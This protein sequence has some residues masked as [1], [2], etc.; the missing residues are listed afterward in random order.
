MKYGVYYAYWETQW[1]ADYVKYCKKV[2][3]LGF[4]I[5]EIAG[6]GLGDMTDGERRELRDVSKDLGIT[7]TTGIGLPADVNVSSLDESVRRKG[8]DYMKHLIR[9][10]DAIDSR[11]IGGTV[12]AYWPADYSKPFDKEAERAQS[13]K[14]VLELSDYAADYGVT[15]LIET[16]NRFE[17]YLINDSHE[18]LAYM[19]DVNRENVKMLLDVFHMNIEEDSIAEGIRRLK[20]YIGEIHAGEKNRKVPGK[21]TMPWDEFA[22]ALHEVGFDGNV[23]ME[24]F[25]RPGGIVGSDVKLWRDLSGGADEAKLDQDIAES[26]VFLKGKLEK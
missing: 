6:G 3:N 4:D 13:I 14:S 22:Q 23:V 21:G 19:Q 18:A 12:H 17:Q 9:C 2:K 7:L 15:L 1:A 16:L 10:M 11:S 25:V 24:P 8:I 26:L 20:G 5:L